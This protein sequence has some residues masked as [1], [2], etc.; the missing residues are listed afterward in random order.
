M[1]MSRITTPSPAMLAER[2]PRRSRT[3]PALL[4]FAAILAI[5]ALAADDFVLRFLAEILIFGIAVM[6]LDLLVGYGGL[7]SLGHA[8][9]FGGAAYA[10]ALFA[11]RFGGD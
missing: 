10:A 5:P 11:Q 4:L 2:S 7:V 3:V 1:L 8:A 9:F 6:S